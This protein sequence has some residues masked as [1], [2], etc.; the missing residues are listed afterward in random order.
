VLGLC[1][2][3]F[4]EE[5][6]NTHVVLLGNLQERDRLEDLEVDGSVLLKWILKKYER[7]I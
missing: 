7:N 1:N 5:K 6:R 4:V 3:G 2:S